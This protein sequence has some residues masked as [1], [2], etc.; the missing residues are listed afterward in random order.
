MKYFY[1]ILQ[2]MPQ[3]KNYMQTNFQDFSFFFSFFN[4]NISDT[5]SSEILGFLQA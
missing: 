2:G 4:Q 1:I 3:L 5:S